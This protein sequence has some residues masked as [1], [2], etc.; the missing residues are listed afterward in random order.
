MLPAALPV[1]PRDRWTRGIE[2]C[3]VA[4]GSM[5]AIDFASRMLSQPERADASAIIDAVP[6]HSRV[7]PV[8]FSWSS[9]GVSDLPV[10]VHHAAYTVV[11]RQSETTNMFSRR[12]GT[13]PIRGR[14]PAN[15]S[16]PEVGFEWARSFDPDAM[17]AGYFDTVMVR[18]P[19]S[20]PAEDPAYRV[21]GPSATYA[22]RLAHFGRFWLYHFDRR[23]LR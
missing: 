17:Y 11:R 10:Y 3:V 14:W 7:A 12:F 16:L 6:A 1:P 4:L 5:G 8:F 9:P 21:F 20:Q 23:G 22:M 2:A 15:A 19:D 13:F 18:T